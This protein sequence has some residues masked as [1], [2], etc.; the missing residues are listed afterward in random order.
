M[1]SM[2]KIISFATDFGLEDGSVGV[3]KGVINRIDPELKVNDISH[4]IPAQDIR[5]GSLLLMRAIQYIPQGVLLG[6][7]DPGVG[8]ER[9]AIGIETEWGVMIGPDNGLLNL[10]CATVG[11]AQRAFLLAT[12]GG[13]Q[14]AF[15]LENTDWIIPSEGSTFHARDIFSPFAAGYA[16]G[17][18]A[19]EEFGPEVD[20]GDLKQYLIPLTD[21]SE[22]EIKGEVL[23]V[24]HFGNCQ[25]NVSPEELRS[26]NLSI[27]D[28][29]NVTVGSRSF[30][31][32]WCES[33]QSEYLDNVGLITDLI[34][35][36][37]GMVLIFRKNGNA[38]EILECKDSSKVSFSI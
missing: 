25:T 32:T 9:K 28:V 6:V 20:L 19:L 35:D 15:L 4:G 34:T 38:A 11:G 14:R 23:Y 8:T 17:Q 10:A 7:V 5:Y 2:K 29:V 27:G 31:T 18:L 12:V 16:S 26:L 37:W 22:K 1:K 21:V 33:F 36:S 13:A 30:K 3:V 24:D